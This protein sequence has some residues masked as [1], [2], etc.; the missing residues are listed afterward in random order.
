M[1]WCLMRRVVAILQLHY[2]SY[3]IFSAFMVYSK[4]SYHIYLFQSWIVEESKTLPKLILYHWNHCHI[5][6]ECVD[7]IPPCRLLLRLETLLSASFWSTPTLLEWNFWPFHF[8]CFSFFGNII[9]IDHLEQDKL[10]FCD[11]F[12]LLIATISYWRNCWGF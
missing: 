7:I 3:L 8:L 5:N 11:F 6:T 1:L 10:I 9:E 4:I 2:D 12:T